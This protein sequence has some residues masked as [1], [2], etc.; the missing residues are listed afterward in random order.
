M[1]NIYIVF[2]EPILPPLLDPLQVSVTK[3][4]CA[5]GPMLCPGPKQAPQDHLPRSG[6]GLQSVNPG[7]E[8]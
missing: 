8:L 7:P 2:T 5:M 1:Y 3:I 4:P 6:S